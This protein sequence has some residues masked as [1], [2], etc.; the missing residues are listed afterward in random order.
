MAAE[1]PDAEVDQACYRYYSLHLHAHSFSGLRY[2][3][4]IKEIY[5]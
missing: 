5:G 3:Q 2:H 1:T 4:M